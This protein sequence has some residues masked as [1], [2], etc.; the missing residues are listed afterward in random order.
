GF[1]VRGPAGSPDVGI[2]IYGGANLTLSS[3][4]VTDIRTRL[5]SGFN[6]PG[7]TAI[8]VGLSDNKRFP[9]G[10]VGVATITDVNVTNYGERG[11][12][13]FRSGSRAHI[14]SNHVT[15]HGS[16]FQA[17]IMIGQNAIATVVNNEVSNNT[18]NMPPVCGDDPLNQGQSIGIG[19]SGADI[20]THIA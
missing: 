1:T 11:M 20:N 12:T 13:V 15:G 6:S 17:G 4:D 16:A 14:Q 18:C 3:V 19:I 8:G 9:G 2:G 7:G 5:D 10:Q